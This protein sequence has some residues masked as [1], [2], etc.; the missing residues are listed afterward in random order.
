M[1]Q[2]KTGY[3]IKHV[4]DGDFLQDDDN[5]EFGPLASA[6]LFKLKREAKANI[7]DADTQED[8]IIQKARITTEIL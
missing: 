6:Y 8:E 4:I 7:D 1:K 2:V 5:A 3:V